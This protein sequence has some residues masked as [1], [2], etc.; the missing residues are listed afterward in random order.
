[1]TRLEWDKIDERLYETGIDRG[2]LYLPSSPGIYD[3]GVAWNGLISVD[4]DFGN[5]DPK[6]SF[7]DGVKYLD[8]YSFG[9]FAATLNAYTYP[10]EFLPFQG[11]VD[12]GEGVYIDIQG[13]EVF[14]MSYRTM[15]TNGEYRIHLLYNLTAVPDDVTYSS[16]N[17]SP[18]PVNFSWSIFGVPE[19]AFDFRPTSH[20]ILDS[21]F[22][23][24]EMLKILEDIIY[25]HSGY[26]S[27]TGTIDG[28]F[29]W[30]IQTD[31]LDG[32]L[33]GNVGPGT[34]DGETIIL[35]PVKPSLPHLE[36]LIGMV[37]NLHPRIIMPERVTGLS[38]LIDGSGDLTSSHIPGIY[39]DLPLTRLAP[40]EIEGLYLLSGAIE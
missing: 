37:V 15:L 23:S 22:L 14:G 11:V 9:D 6:A 2:V 21:R 17:D 33:A 38:Y 29:P 12:I 18:E 39:D 27:D 24:D 1:M 30:T 5:E 36:D 7:F 10:D 19:S 34:V 32:G 31:E 4:E 35:P 25:G 3:D 40:S 26:S 8:R 16:L 20:V 13:P 28:L